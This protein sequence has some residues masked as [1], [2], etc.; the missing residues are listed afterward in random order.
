MAS[1]QL[2]QGINGKRWQHNEFHSKQ[3]FV[4]EDELHLLA[5]GVFTR[6]LFLGFL[7]LNFISIQITL[8]KLRIFS[9]VQ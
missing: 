8:L 1:S 4:N 2:F 3:G 5:V 9:V 6:F 7:C